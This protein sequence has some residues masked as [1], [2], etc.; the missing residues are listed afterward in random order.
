MKAISNER[1]GDDL[2]LPSLNMKYI[3]KQYDYRK[4]DL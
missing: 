3:T 1:E 2:I 4:M